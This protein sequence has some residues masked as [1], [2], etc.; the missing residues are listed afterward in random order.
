M[1]WA[2]VIAVAAAAFL[3]AIAAVRLPRKG[4]TLFAAVLVFGLT[5]YALQGSPTQPAAMKSASVDTNT[6]ASGEA[7]VEARR[8]LFDQTQLSPDYLMLSDGFARRGRYQEAAQILSG[9]LGEN[10][11]NGE[12]WLAL[13]NA[14]VEHADG[15]VTP[16]ALQAFA[17]A[18][19]RLNG[20]PAPAY[21]LGAA[22]IRSAK[23]AEALE[24]WSQ[25]LD[26]TPPD[27]PWREDLAFRVEQLRLMIDTAP[28]ISAQTR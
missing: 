20:H 8:S 14:L 4:W 28:G 16:A 12:A 2:A 21:F 7:M 24:V 3:I 22:L 15:Q 19:D 23:P 11:D 25:L 6:A 17:R 13:A 10:S 1:I 9:R 27:A 18:E 26:A 5:G